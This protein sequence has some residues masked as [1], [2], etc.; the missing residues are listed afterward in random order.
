[1]QDRPEAFTRYASL[2]GRTVIVTGG[3]S[4]IGEAMVRAFAANGCRVAF[5]DILEEAGSTLAEAMAERHGAR[6]LFI[7]CD[8]TDIGALRA[9]MERIHEALG[10]AAALVNNAANDQR[11]DFASVEPDAFDWTI[12]VNL[13]HAYFAA[14]AVAPQMRDCGGGSIINMSSVAWMNG[15]AELEAYSAAKAAMVGLTNALARRLGPDR[16]RVNAIAPAMVLTDRQRRLWFRDESRIAASLARQCLPDMITPEDVARLALFL[17]ADDS[18]MITRQ[19][20]VVSGGS[21]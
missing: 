20:L 12:A 14:Q 17:A 13:R 2:E 5:L 15:V 1:M 7:P 16:I 19:C 9:A 11:Q 21:R 3:A 18:A 8:L 4:G 6:P 10:P